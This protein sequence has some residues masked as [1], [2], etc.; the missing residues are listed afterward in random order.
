MKEFI[1]TYEELVNLINKAMISKSEQDFEE[2]IL[3]KP[4]TP[5]YQVQ[6][7]LTEQKLKQL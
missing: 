5:F 6:R 4:Y 1:F 2:G 7:F 3:V